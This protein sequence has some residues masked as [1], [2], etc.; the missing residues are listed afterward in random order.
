MSVQADEATVRQFL[1]IISSHAAHVINGVAEK[2]VLQLCRLNPADEKIVP[3]R[4]S[5]DDVDEM[6]KTA[7]G[8]AAAGHN[9]YIEARTVR[10]DLRGS[11]RGGIDDTAWV[12]GLVAD[13]DA[14]KNK[15]GN[16]TARP[17]IA[18][19][20]S[21]GNF[22]L[23]YL[24]DR[25]IPAAQAKL[26]GDAIRANSGA[27]QDTA[28]SRNVT[29]WP[30]PPTSH[31]RRSAPADAPPWSQPGSLNIPDGCGIPTNCWRRFRCPRRRKMPDRAPAATRSRSRTIS[32]KSSA[33]A[34]TRPRTARRC[35]TV[36]WR[37]SSGGAGASKP[38]LRCL[39]NIR[40]VSPKNTSNACARRSSAH[41]A[42]SRR[43]RQAQLPAPAQP[44]PGLAADPRREHALHPTS[45]RP[46]V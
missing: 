38:S 40:T 12:F 30:A 25:A 26:I 22:H 43:L 33:K 39:K 32:W 13:C 44:A 28:S 19:E 7:T 29:V 42:R 15:G 4:F 17:S 24:L 1:K 2:G 16:I 37:N 23:W 41:T 27:D 8:D 46:S 35:F 6:V 3:S 10:A 36:R 21:I 5:I 18:V 34:A 20:T 11:R 45:S 31:R 14:D 9:V